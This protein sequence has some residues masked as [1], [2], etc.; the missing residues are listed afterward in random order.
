MYVYIYI[1]T[2]THI[3]IYLYTC[4]HIYI[5]IYTHISSGLLSGQRHARAPAAEALRIARG[6]APARFGA[7]APEPD[8]HGLVVIH[9][10]K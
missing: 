3:H 1:Y 10:Y 9:S 6:R 7:D 4:R 8:E 5:Y 2:H